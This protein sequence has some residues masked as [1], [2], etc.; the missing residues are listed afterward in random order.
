MVSG[1]MPES[2][3]VILMT[4]T[5]SN[6]NVTIFRRNKKCGRD[7]TESGETRK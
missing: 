4:K 3:R 5:I 2:F 1:Q 7:K 6:I